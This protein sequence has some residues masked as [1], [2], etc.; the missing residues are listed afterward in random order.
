MKTPILPAFTAFTALALLACTDPSASESGTDQGSDPTSTTTDDPD[1]EGST[2]GP[3]TSEPDGSDTS[4]LD[5]TGG[6]TGTSTDDDPERT[7]IPEEGVEFIEANG[8]QF[9]YFA[10]GEGPLVLLLH[11]F[12]DTPHTFDDLRPALAA[13][14]FFAVSPFMRGYTPSSIPAGD[15][16]DAQTLGEDALALIEAFGEQEAYIVGHDF[17]AFAAYAAASLDPARVRRLVTVAIPHPGFF[18]P[19][20]EFFERA[21]HFIYLAED[22]AEALMRAD[23][24]AHVD[25]LYARWSPTWRFEPAE[26]EP[27]KNAFAA[28]GS[29]NAALGYYRASSPVPPPF[30]Q[31]PLPMDTLTIAGL[32]DGV[33]L[34]E[35]FEQTAAGFSGEW[36][37]LTV[38]GGHFVHRENP[39][40]V[41]PAV[42]EFLASDGAGE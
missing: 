27:V 10:E 29:L 5:S 32:D 17:G 14:G 22:D 30:L 40:Q 34:P 8:E 19:D 2:A 15:A 7:H 39:G 31:V 13:A 9:G 3:D 21:S 23:D 18:V 16:F 37:L 42:V 28:P 36:T 6:S 38:D 20:P 1:A 11:G 41:V 24:F 4:S 26:T 33:M 12:P 25:E 35:G